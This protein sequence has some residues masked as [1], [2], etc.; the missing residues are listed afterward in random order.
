M[1]NGK[2]GISYTPIKSLEQ[3]VC[4]PSSAATMPKAGNLKG[5][6]V[7]EFLDEIDYVK[8]PLKKTL[9]IAIINALATT[10]FTEYMKENFLIEKDKDPIDKIEIQEDTYTVVVGALVPY[11]KKL[12][13][14]KRKFSILELDPKTLKENELKY[15]WPADKA[16]EIVNKADYLIITGT[17]LINDTLEELLCMAKKKA[18]IIVV[19]PTVSMLPKALFKRNVK[20]IGGVEVIN[21]DVLLDT[22]SEAGSGYHFFGKTANKIVISRKE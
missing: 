6:K 9:I 3:A 4:C 18:T 11:I 22:L 1:S 17:T 7:K 20:Y 5:K 21:P 15:F 19:G 2:G 14:E 13:K 10:C 16:N 8:S 12:I